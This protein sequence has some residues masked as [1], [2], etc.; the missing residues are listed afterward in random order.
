MENIQMQKKKKQKLSHIKNDYDDFIFT[1]FKNSMYVKDLRFLILD[2]YLD[3]PIFNVNISKFPH[4]KP[5]NNEI[6]EEQIKFDR[7]ETYDCYDYDIEI[8]F[9]SDVFHCY[10]YWKALLKFKVYDGMVLDI[11][12]YYLSDKKLFKT[13]Y[14]GPDSFKINNLGDKEV[15]YIETYSND[16]IINLKF[17]YYSSNKMVS[18]FSISCVQNHSKTEFTTYLLK[19]EK[20]YMTI[21]SEVQSLKFLPL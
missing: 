3:N 15:H 9:D 7:T 19:N 13:I 8:H 11:S 1:E 10:L 21:S 17:L 20:F 18:E 6:L 4:N 12:I 5:E 16:S 14:L 2:Y